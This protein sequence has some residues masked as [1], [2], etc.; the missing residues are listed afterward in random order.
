MLGGAFRNFGM[1][2]FRILPAVPAGSIK[3]RAGTCTKSA[4]H[5]KRMSSP[6]LEFGAPPRLW[7]D[8]SCQPGRQAWGCRLPTS[9]SAER[10]PNGK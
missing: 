6:R 10:Q 3:Q 1:A 7:T 2:M 8:W 9:P 5:L 4:A